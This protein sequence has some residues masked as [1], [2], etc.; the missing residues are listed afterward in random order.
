MALSLTE[1]H[2]PKTLADVYGQ[3]Y[4]VSQLTAFLDNPYS[5]GMLFHGRT[6]T[7]KTSA[8][9]ALAGELGIDIPEGEWGGW[10]TISAGD[11][12][13]DMVRETIRK[14][15]TTPMGSKNGYRMILVDEA[16]RMG[17][18]VRYLWLSMLEDLPPKTIVVFTTNHKADFEDRF[19]DRIGSD[20]YEF[21]HDGPTLLQD[22]QGLIRSVWERETG[23]ADGAPDAAS[24][25]G[26]ID[27][28]GAISMRRVV[29]SLTG[30]LRAW[31]AAHAVK[32]TPAPVKPPASVAPALDDPK[33]VR[34]DLNGLELP[35][36]G[37]RKPRAVESMPYKLVPPGDP[38][39]TFDFSFWSTRMPATA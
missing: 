24:V 11:Q 21:A 36:H 5:C 19:I 18:P 9:H 37:Y 6:G 8:A 2:R 34:K 33:P 3:G 26:L 22:A 30:P 20:C 14:A 16:D 32:P 23:S 28:D 38:Q 29:S 25:P 39:R 13:A 4:V 10:F 35:S 15:R 31:H 27:K 12:T 17:K 1:K 7:G